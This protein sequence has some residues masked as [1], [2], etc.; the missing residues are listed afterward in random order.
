MLRIE[1]DVCFLDVRYIEVRPVDLA[2][3]ES[4]FG[5]RVRIERGDLQLSHF[6]LARLPEF[7]VLAQ[8]N[9]LRG[10]R[11]DEIR[12]CA[13]RVRICVLGAIT[14]HRG[15]HM[16]GQNIRLPS[17]IPQKRIERLVERYLYCICIGCAYGFDERRDAA[18][19]HC[20]IFLEQAEGK[21]DIITGEWL[22]I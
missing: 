21:Y 19:I 5:T 1:I 12:A 3:L 6:R 18:E 7:R 9:E 4:Q 10:E 16:F 11:L 15:P 8:D 20:R 14:F 13:N 17:Q 2:F 22:T